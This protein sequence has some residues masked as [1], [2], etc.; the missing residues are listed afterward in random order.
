MNRPAEPGERLT[1]ECGHHRSITKS[2]STAIVGHC[3]CVECHDLER[4]A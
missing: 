3:P 2:G 4:I 1:Q